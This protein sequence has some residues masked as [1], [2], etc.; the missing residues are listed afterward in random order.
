MRG[1]PKGVALRRAVV[2]SPVSSSPTAMDIKRV[3]GDF[4]DAEAGDLTFSTK[5]ARSSP[6]AGRLGPFDQWL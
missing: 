5:K 2:T 4:G 6:V 1:K 3:V